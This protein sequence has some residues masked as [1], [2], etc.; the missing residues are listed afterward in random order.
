MKATVILVVIGALGTVTEGF[1]KE[2]EEMEIRIRVESIQTTTL[3]RL[4]RK[5]RSIQE[6]NGDLLSLKLQ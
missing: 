5:L 1:V 3:L 2:L 6:T 4:V